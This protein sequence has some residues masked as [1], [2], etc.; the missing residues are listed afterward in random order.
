MLHCIDLDLFF[1]TQGRVLIYFLILGKL[2]WGCAYQKFYVKC[3]TST[4]TRSIL[5]HCSWKGTKVFFAMRF[6]HWLMWY[7]VFIA[8]TR[9]FVPVFNDVDKVI[10]QI[11]S[12]IIQFQRFLFSS[13]RLIKKNRNISFIY[14]MYIWII[15]RNQML[16]VT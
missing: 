3:Q 13:I 10:F 15:H 8:D 16:Y 7:F 6:F 1:L 9:L 12:N 4:S 5:I 11:I 2:V 14:V